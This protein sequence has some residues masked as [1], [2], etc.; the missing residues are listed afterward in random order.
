MAIMFVQFSNKKPLF[1]VW[2]KIVWQVQDLLYLR[3]LETMSFSAVC[4]YDD[5]DWKIEKSIILKIRAST[6]P[7]FIFS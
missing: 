6:P 5:F 3:R 7:N 1:F 2:K 4:P